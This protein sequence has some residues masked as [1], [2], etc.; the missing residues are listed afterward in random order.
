MGISIQEFLAG[1]EPCEVCDASGNQHHCITELLS[2]EDSCILFN[3][4]GYNQDFNTPN[5]TALL[6]ELR[7][8]LDPQVV[9]DYYIRSQRLTAHF[10]SMPNPDDIWN[11][12]YWDH[13][14][15]ILPE[16]R[17][18]KY[19]LVMQ[20]I[21]SIVTELEIQYTGLTSH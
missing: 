21:N 8:V 6:Q 3:S 5:D 9:L 20:R 14:R 10:R 17:M 11:R 15:Y 13:V 19:D 2:R 4:I 18:R 1:R 16:L 12:I 7:S